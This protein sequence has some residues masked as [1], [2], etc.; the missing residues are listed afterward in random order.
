MLV[1]AHRA[2][3]EGISKSEENTLPAVRYCLERGWGVE[4]DIRRATNGMFYV[5]HDPSALNDAN[6]ADAFCELIRRYP[7]AIIALNVKELGYE[8][9]LLEYLTQ[10]GISS[11]VFLFDMELLEGHPGQS[12]R[13]FRQ[14]DPGIR[15]AAR[16]SDRD[17]PIDRALSIE[18]ADIIWVDEFDRL[19]ITE[20]DV[21]RLKSAGKMVYAI[22]PEIHGFTLEQMYQRWRQFYD[23]G[24]DGI[25]TDYA[26]KLARRIAFWN[27][28][29]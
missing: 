3:R 6:H 2:N 19:W 22:S 10:Q 7:G 11:Q 26:V 14:L 24:V 28:G 1:L 23:W 27:K 25:C 4:I 12:A 5:S 16:V 21:H 13:L 15:L 29:G 9:D 18:Q 20:V 17:E 8:A